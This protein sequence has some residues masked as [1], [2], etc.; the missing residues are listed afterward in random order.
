[1]VFLLALAAL[2]MTGISVQTHAVKLSIVLV[3]CKT[4]ALE[5]QYKT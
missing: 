4:T 5:Y 1:M 2:L 3:M